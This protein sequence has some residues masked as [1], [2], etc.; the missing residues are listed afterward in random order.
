MKYKIKI[1]KINFY[2]GKIKI[3]YVIYENNKIC[4]SGTGLSVTDFLIYWFN[5]IIRQKP[6]IKF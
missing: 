1:K 2:K 4:M 3:N 6:I 5:Y